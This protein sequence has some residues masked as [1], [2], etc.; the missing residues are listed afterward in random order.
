M[1]KQ[2]AKATAL[3]LMLL[4]CGIEER[5]PPLAQ[6]AAVDGSDSAPDV[7]EQR[8]V[9]DGSV[10]DRNAPDVSESGA[11]NVVDSAV[12]NILDSPI[13]DADG[14]GQDGPTCI[15]GARR[16]QD[17]H[18]EQCNGTSW[19]SLGNCDVA[20]PYCY[21]GAC[22]ACQPGTHRC[23]GSAL[24]QCSVTGAWAVQATCSGTT[25]VCNAQTGSCVGTRLVGG[26]ST[27][28]PTATAPSGAR[29]VGGELLLL[30]RVCNGAMGACV[31]GGFVP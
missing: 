13:A 15:V 31:Q 16:C 6:D 20:M 25:P 2:L 17:G 22:L 23:M 30:P 4:A 10:I 27:L 18:P 14:S 28:G 7:A 3:T 8:D 11:S 12:E 5:L 26:F 29:V 24:E 19:Q 1:V 21:A 9:G